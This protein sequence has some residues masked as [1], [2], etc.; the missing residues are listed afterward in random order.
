MF[1][2]RYVYTHSKSAKAHSK[3][4][5]STILLGYPQCFEI[6]FFLHFNFENL[7]ANDGTQTDGVKWWSF[8]KFLVAK[9][10]VEKS[11]GFIHC[12]SS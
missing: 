7:P 11:I 2:Y 12:I 3:L 4:M 10:S 5:Q 8:K 6:F 9:Y 1:T